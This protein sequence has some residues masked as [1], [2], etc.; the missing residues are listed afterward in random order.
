MATKTTGFAD[1]R[2]ST[3]THDSPGTLFLSEAVTA[4]TLPHAHRAQVRERALQR[5]EDT[6]LSL[7]QFM[8]RAFRNSERGLPAEKRD[9]APPPSA[10][11]GED[12]ETDDEGWETD[13][14]GD[15]G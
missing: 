15:E 14:D 2:L 11:D 5:Q 9:Q 12:S 3:A 4:S 8:Q 1:D 7:Q 13:S 6:S 10:A